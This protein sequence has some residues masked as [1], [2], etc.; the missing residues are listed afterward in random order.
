LNITSASSRESGHVAGN[1][2]QD[3]PTPPGFICAFRFA[4]AEAL[5]LSW[6]EA[7]REIA[8]EGPT[9]LHLSANDDTVESWLTGVT[10]MPDVA[11]EFLNGFSFVR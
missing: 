4:G 11:R 9:W 3:A 8:G 7:R 10:A 5:R 6:D 2:V 1:A